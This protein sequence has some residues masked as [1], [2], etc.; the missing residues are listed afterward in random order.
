MTPAFVT[1]PH[2]AVSCSAQHLPRGGRRWDPFPHRRPKALLLLHP[3]TCFCRAPAGRVASPERPPSEVPPH[4]DGAVR[5]VPRGCGLS[6]S[7]WNHVT[8]TEHAQRQGCPR[9]MERLDLSL[10]RA[11]GAQGTPPTKRDSRDV[12]RGQEF[13]CGP[14]TE[15]VG[16]VDRGGG[17]QGLP[18]RPDRARTPGPS[19]DLCLALRGPRERWQV[20]RGPA[21]EWGPE[22]ED[23]LGVNRGPL[24]PAVLDVTVAASLSQTASMGARFH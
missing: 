21:Q 1:V 9:P 12:C 6:G 13:G 19:T 15:Q 7:P 14:H 3:D 17:T 22:W 20:Q 5:G 10:R 2:Q 4:S 8:R 23:L 11:H 18:G 16:S 24:S